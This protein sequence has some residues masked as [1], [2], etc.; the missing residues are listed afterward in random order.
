[1]ECGQRFGG[2]GGV[3]FQDWP[4]M[5]GAALQELGPHYPRSKCPLSWREFSA[6][7]GGKPR[8]DLDV[9]FLPGS[10]FFCSIKSVPDVAKPTS[11]CVMNRF[12]P[13]GYPPIPRPIWPSLPNPS[14]AHL[15]FGG[16]VGHCV[17]RSLVARGLHL[18]CHFGME[19]VPQTSEPLFHV[20]EQKHRHPNSKTRR[21]SIS[22]SLIQST[23]H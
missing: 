13:L 10:T 7:W 21:M 6:T 20:L 8:N 14:L 17:T 19:L 18:A 1:M 23:C 2:G 9:V 4:S 12:H 3:D 11:Q 15:I 5:P 16:V 22:F